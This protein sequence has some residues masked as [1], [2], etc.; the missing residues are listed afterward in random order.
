MAKQ[1]LCAS[2]ITVAFDCVDHDRPWNTLRSMG[3][4]QHLIALIKSLY[5]NQEAAVK[6]EYGNT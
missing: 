3:V 2:Q 4:T 5:T 6:T 1:Y